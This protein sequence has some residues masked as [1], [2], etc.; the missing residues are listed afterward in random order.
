MMN[1]KPSTMWIHSLLPWRGRVERKPF[2]LFSLAISVFM[3]LF[4][5]EE[6]AEALGGS[7]GRNA[8]RLGMTDSDLIVAAFYAYYLGIWALA[9]WLAIA[10]GAKRAR[11]IGGTAWVL[12]IYCIPFVN[13][14]LGIWL[15]VTP[16]DYQ[17]NRAFAKVAK[18][19]DP[20]ATVD[21]A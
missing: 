5:S 14:V 12:L 16:T 6:F 21:T 3:A 18:A 19:A 13:A 9:F 10:M 17:R 20:I 2:I 1:V 11:D 4:A 7:F 15:L 8:V